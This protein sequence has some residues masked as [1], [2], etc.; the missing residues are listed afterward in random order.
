MTKTL[1]FFTLL[2]FVL[3]GFQTNA[4]TTVTVF[5]QILFYDGYAP[6]VDPVLYPTSE[7]VI[8]HRN[9]LYARKLTDDEL[10]SFGNDLTINVTIGAACDNYDRIGNVNLVLVP[11]GDATYDASNVT[12]IELARFITPFMNKN[13]TPTEVPYTWTANNVA[14]IFKDT[15]ILT[16]YDIWAELQVFGVPYA[17]QTQVAGCAGQIDVFYGTLEFVSSNSNAVDAGNYLLPLEFQH[18]LNDYQE[19]ASDAIGTTA[20]TINF[21]LPATIANAKFYLITSNHGAN[22]GG[23]EYIRRNH[24]VYLDGTQLLMYKPGG[25]SCEPWRMYNTQPNGIYGPTPRTFAQWASFSNWC[26]GNIIPIRVIDLGDL[27]PGSHEFKITVPTAVFADDQGYFPISVY[28]QGTDTTLGSGGFTP[29]QYSLSPNP[30]NGIFDVRASETVEHITV[31]NLLGQRVV[32]AIGSR[33]D[34]SDAAPGVYIATI[35]FAN[36]KSATERIIRK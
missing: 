34:L 36:G 8:R 30:T 10:A 24:Y 23:E 1:R 35:A 17:A 13:I 16:V 25:I 20:W 6:V 11:K 12:R 7:G 15:A 18:Y 3:L 31:Y 22:A 32:S 29:L 19:G 33:V 2:L 9:D 27:A 14:S 21:D 26:P 28:L 4:Q 5:D